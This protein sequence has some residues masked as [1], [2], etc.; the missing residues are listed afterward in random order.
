MDPTVPDEGQGRSRGDWL[1]EVHRSHVTYRIM[2][3][4]DPDVTCFCAHEW[5]SDG[6]GDGGSYLTCSRVMVVAFPPVL[7][8]QL[9]QEAGRTGRFRGGVLRPDDLVFPPR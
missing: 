8:R 7:Q 5:N 9:L 6:P 4:Y 3:S 2:L 1:G